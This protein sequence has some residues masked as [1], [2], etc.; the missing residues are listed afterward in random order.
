MF[1][2]NITPIFQKQLFKNLD[3]SLGFFIQRIVQMSDNNPA[4]FPPRISVDV[5]KYIESINSYWQAI[6]L[7]SNRNIY[8]QANFNGLEKDVDK[9]TSILK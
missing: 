5:L 7:E 6:S 1:H 8:T 3:Y 9:L 4:I 2:P